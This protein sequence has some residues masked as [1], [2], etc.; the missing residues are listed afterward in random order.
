MKTQ[1]NKTIPKTKQ[2]NNNNNNKSPPKIS[3]RQ[4]KSKHKKEIHLIFSNDFS[5]VVYLFQHQSIYVIEI[6]LSVK[7]HFFLQAIV[8]I[9]LFEAISFSIL[10]TFR[11]PAKRLFT[12]MNFFS[13]D[14]QTYNLSISRMWSIKILLLSKNKLLLTRIKNSENGSLWC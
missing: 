14:L 6:M 11:I 1:K 7:W 10:L 5:H 3:Q 4:N 2:T 9:Q 13:L 8:F 12:F